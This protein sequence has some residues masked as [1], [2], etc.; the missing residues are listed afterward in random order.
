MW[1]TLYVATLELR[2][3]TL[4]AVIVSTGKMRCASASLLLADSGV[5]CTT[6]GHWASNSWLSH[7]IFLTT[8]FNFCWDPVETSSMFIPVRWANKSSSAGFEDTKLIPSPPGKSSFTYI[9]NWY[10][11]RI[12]L[13]K[14]TTVT[15]FSYYVN[16]SVS[17][18]KGCIFTFMFPADAAEITR[19]RWNR[20]QM[21]NFS[22]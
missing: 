14:T 2:F 20:R 7:C 18:I 4:S 3:G 17:I 22:I 10:Y 5:T 15:T 13:R 19:R 11:V 16:C 1:H 8:R 9:N 12:K 6:T 21:H